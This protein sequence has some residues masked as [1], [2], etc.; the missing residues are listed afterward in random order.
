M[1]ENIHARG[2]ERELFNNLLRL[3]INLQMHAQ[4]TLRYCYYDRL[5]YAMQRKSTVAQTIS[6]SI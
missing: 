3:R 1:N 6:L 2:R 4:S 5:Q